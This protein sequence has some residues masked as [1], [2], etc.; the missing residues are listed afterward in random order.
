[1]FDHVTHPNIPVMAYNRF[2]GMI[3]NKF[4]DKLNII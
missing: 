2:N 3:W 4:M 1:M